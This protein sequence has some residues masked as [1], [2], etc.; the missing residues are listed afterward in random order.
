MFSSELFEFR[1]KIFLPVF[2]QI[3]SIFI[4]AT[5]LKHLEEIGKYANVV[6]MLR[7]VF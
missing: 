5:Y 4:L 2:F 1:S 3:D 6:S 7:S